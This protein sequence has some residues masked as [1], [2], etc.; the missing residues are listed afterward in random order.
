MLAVQGAPSTDRRK[1]PGRDDSAERFARASPEHERAMMEAIDRI[2]ATDLRVVQAGAL[3]TRVDALYPE[4]VGRI[5]ESTELFR[6][7]IRSEGH[8]AS[9]FAIVEG[10]AA[11][12]GGSR[13]F[14]KFAVLYATLRI[15]KPPG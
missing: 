1:P 10:S 13:S 7:E 9:A 5:V 4:D 8:E 2:S 15:S 3:L 14:E 6:R 11:V 12:A